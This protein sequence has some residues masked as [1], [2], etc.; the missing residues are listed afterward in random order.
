MREVSEQ[1]GCFYC[2]VRKPRWKVIGEKAT[3]WACSTH[4]HRVCIDVEVGGVYLSKVGESRY[5]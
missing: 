1:A 5:D 2:T 3:R 4:L